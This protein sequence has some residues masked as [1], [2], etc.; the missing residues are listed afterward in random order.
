MVQANQG[1][2]PN[3]RGP[4]KPRQRGQ[5]L[6]LRPGDLIFFWGNDLVSKAIEIVTFGPSH[7]GIMTMY[8]GQF[9]LAEATTLC[10]HKCEAQA[11]QIR[12]FQ[13]HRLPDRLT[14]YPKGQAYAYC[15]ASDCQLTQAQTDQL[16]Q[17]ATGAIGTDYDY[18]NAG[19]SATRF[20]KYLNPYPDRKSL[21]CSALVA[22]FYQRLGLLNWS[23]PEIWSPS[24]LRATLLRNAVIEKGQQIL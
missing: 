11:K 6:S 1:K 16:E 14:D 17:L 9:L 5:M 18:F 15:L 13:F 10:R 3:Q 20:L 23:S 7:V 21:F 22:R 12:G 19:L 24:A 4:T 2:G 8:Q